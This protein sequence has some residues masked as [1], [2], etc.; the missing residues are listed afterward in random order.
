[1]IAYESLSP[2]LYTH[3]LALA[4]I[5]LYASGLQFPGVS[6]ASSSGLPSGVST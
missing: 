1:M 4:Q 5:H 6:V 2:L 3:I